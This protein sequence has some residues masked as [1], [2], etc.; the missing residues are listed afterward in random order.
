MN[1]KLYLVDVSSMFFRAFYA[2]RPLTSPSGTPVNAVYG[3]LSMIIKILQDEKPTKMAFC[4]DRKEPSFRKELYTAYKANRS[5]M[6]E[7]LVPQ[8]PLIQELAELLGIPS[9]SV[10]GY[11]ADDLIGTLAH[12]GVKNNTEVVIV[13]GDKDFGQIVSEQVCLWDTMKNI[14]YNPIS[15]KEK[16]GVSPDQ[17]I[18]YLAIVGDSS[19]NVPGVAGLGPKGAIKLLEQFG[20]LS[21]IYQNLDAISSQSIKE[22]LQKSKDMAFLSQKLVTIVNDVKLSENLNEYQL[23]GY[24]KPALIEFLQKL[25]F[26][27]FEKKLFPEDFESSTATKNIESE[28][29]Y[30]S[31]QIFQSPPSTSSTSSVLNLKFTSAETKPESSLTTENVSS[32]KNIIF[33]SIDKMVYLNLGLKQVSAAELEACIKA[34]SEVVGFQISDQIY[35]YYG[36]SIFVI[37]EI[38]LE[39]VG[40]WAD[41][42]LIRWSGYNIKELWH[43]LKC[44]SPIA[45]FDV[46]LMA[47]LV[48]SGD[49]SSIEKTFKQVTQEDCPDQMS[50]QFWLYAYHVLNQFF[51]TKLNELKLEKVFEQIENPLVSVLFSMENKGIKVDKKYLQNLQIEFQNEL[52]SLEK[53]IHELAGEDFNVASPKQL[54]VILFEKLKLPALKKTKTGYS[55]D[56]EVL[57]SLKHPIAKPI[58]EYREAAKLKSTYVDSLINL[59]DEIDR[60]HTQ[61]NQATTATGRLS[62]TEPNLQNIPIRTERGRLIRKAFIAEKDNFL[63][64]LDYSQ[65]ELRILAHISQDKALISAFQ[66]DLDIHTATAAE[67]F[68]KSINEVTSDLRRSAK[69]VNFGIAYGQG[70]FGLAENLGIGRKEAQEIINRYFEKFSGV[71]DYIH[72]TIEKAHELGYVETLFGRRRYIH[73]LKSS[74]NMIKKFGERAAI[75]APIQ[76]TASDLVKKAMVEVY[77][78]IDLNMLLQV[79]DELIFEGTFEELS[80][81]KGYIIKIMES[82]MNLIVPLKVNVHIGLNWDEAH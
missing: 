46:M 5:E 31:S 38:D 29:S 14:R 47:Y 77:Q 12:I 82:S 78:R 69:A 26:R 48:Q 40:K 28:Q 30:E 1:N 62:S 49:V 53:S 15:V 72:S 2:V 22:K 57:Q 3:F 55:T 42:R 34:N 80:S 70:A 54:G 41:D 17:F 23:K 58:L 74:N 21:N 60:V 37:N 52:H 64:S 81:Q 44:K 50:P 27:S 16:W 59:A 65:I 9:V 51:S 4:Y 36:N 76:G 45:N 66:N 75:N 35:L 10:L 19:D 63:M 79:H 61:F 8:I 25:N 24:N 73:E 43:R 32:D 18:D 7:E 11:E 33:K 39:E 71:K 67:I 13:S 68:S 6:P 56:N 20:S